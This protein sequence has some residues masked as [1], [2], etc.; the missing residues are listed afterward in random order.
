[1]AAASD[2]I[3]IGFQV[4]PSAAAANMLNKKVWISALYSVIYDAIE[5]VKAAMEGMLA[6]EVEENRLQLPSKCVKY[7]ILLRSVRLP[8]LW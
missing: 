3:I 6:P 8:V 4:R 7:S 2:A 5:E 1:L